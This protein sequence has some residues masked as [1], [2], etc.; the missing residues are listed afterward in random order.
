MFP[1]KCLDKSFVN[2]QCWV[3]ETDVRVWMVLG[4]SSE[5][6]WSSGKLGVVYVETDAPSGKEFRFRSVMRTEHCLVPHTNPAKTALILVRRV[7]GGEN[8][9]KNNKAKL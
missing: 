8:L 1:G 3:Q 9:I 2:Q 5:A 7:G 4:A 6:D